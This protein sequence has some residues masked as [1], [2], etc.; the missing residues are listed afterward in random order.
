MGF[1]NAYS[2]NCALEIVLVTSLTAFPSGEGFNFNAKRA[3]SSNF[4]QRWC[5]FT[6]EILHSP[7]TVL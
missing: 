7:V 3:K 6:R 5:T 1:A 2:T 4:L